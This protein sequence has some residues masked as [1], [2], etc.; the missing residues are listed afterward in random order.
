VFSQLNQIDN[1]CSAGRVA[2][3]GWIHTD[4]KILPAANNARV[5]VVDRLAIGLGTQGNL[6]VLGGAGKMF[7]DDIGLYRIRTAP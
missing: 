1:A 6:T 3:S 2:V 4:A 5:D 7:I